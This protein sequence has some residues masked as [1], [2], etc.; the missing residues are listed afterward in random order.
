[1]FVESHL[2]MSWL[3]WIRATCKINTDIICFIS[4]FPYQTVTSEM[5]AWK[6]SAEETVPILCLASHFCCTR[7]SPRSKCEACLG[8]PTAK[9]Q[10]GKLPSR[11]PCGSCTVLFIPVGHT[12]M[13]RSRLT[14]RRAGTA[15][16]VSCLTPNCRIPH[17]WCSFTGHGGRWAARIF[18]IRCVR[19]LPWELNTSVQAGSGPNP[20][21]FSLLPLWT[22]KTFISFA[23]Q[24]NYFIL[25]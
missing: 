23:S 6:V 20:W 18:V 5:R 8:F 14:L 16:A 19:T 3:W 9:L 25:H 11:H 12:R 7:S 4:S 22:L 2:D 17:W 1:M 21:I 13:S 15:D 24:P 10:P